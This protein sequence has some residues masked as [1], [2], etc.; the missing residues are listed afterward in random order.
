M[1]KYLIPGEGGGGRTEV[2]SKLV[3]YISLS[4]VW[5]FGKFCAEVLKEQRVELCQ[6]IHVIH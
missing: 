2:A 1:M 6:T 5:K 4:I 3:V